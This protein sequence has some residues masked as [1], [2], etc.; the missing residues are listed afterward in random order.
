MRLCITNFMSELFKILIFILFFLFLIWSRLIRSRSAK[1]LGELNSDYIYSL[2]IFFLVVSFFCIIIS[3]IITITKIN[4]KLPHYVLAKVIQQIIAYH[5][6]I[7]KT[8]LSKISEK[9]NLIQG[10]TKPASYL[11]VYF[12]Y[13]HF[14]ISTLV[15]MPTM[16]VATIFFFDIIFYLKIDLF[17]KA[18]P[19]LFV[20]LL[21]NAVI[22]ILDEVSKAQLDYVTAHLICTEHP[23]QLELHLAPESPNIPNALS[24][25]EMKQH[26]NW[27]CQQFDIF[28]NI[29][30]FCDKLI[31]V[32][33][34]YGPWII[35]YYAFLYYYSWSLYLYFLLK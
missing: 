25:K 28:T 2:L 31:I 20:P 12:P 27:L 8:V 21:T 23:N 35:L 1:Y 10:L 9:Y 32:K 22:Y 30:G 16:L 33:Q 14:L 26:F 13:P 4:F 7:P 15:F 24:I 3:T 17:Y 19:L 5:N 34:K 29:K 6:S 18:L 11:V